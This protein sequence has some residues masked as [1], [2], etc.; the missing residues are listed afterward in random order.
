MFRV[1][2]V[3]GLS[4]SL[5]VSL[6][7]LTCVAPASAQKAKDTVRIA[8]EQPIQTVDLIYDPQPQNT[9]LSNNVFDS[10]L[11]YDDQ[12]RE[13]GSL[14][15]QSW[16]RVDDKTIDFTLKQDLRFSVFRSRAL[17]ISSSGT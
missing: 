1:P 11:W 16:K 7:L 10:L 6:A 15:A 4:T 12:K 9:L 13:F 14:L 2:T 3:L 17:S 8:V 5:V